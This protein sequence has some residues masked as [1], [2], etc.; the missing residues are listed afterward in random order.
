MLGI[1][2]KYDNGQYPLAQLYS[3]GVVPA[4]VEALA[5]GAHLVCWPREDQDRTA[6]AA[7]FINFFR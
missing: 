6:F 2:A 3:W 7:L 5:Y 1:A 4:K